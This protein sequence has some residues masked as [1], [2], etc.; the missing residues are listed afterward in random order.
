[1]IKKIPITITVLAVIL[2]LVFLADRLV[3]D[4]S[5]NSTEKPSF[6]VNQ[7]LAAKFDYLSKNGNSSCSLSFKDSISSMPDD[8]KLQGSCC[9]PMSIHRYSEQVEGLKKYANIPEIPPDPYDLEV[10]LA[11]R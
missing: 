10:N 1:M 11:K 5:S 3:F 6:P 7:A 9:G 4:F 2:L 8:A